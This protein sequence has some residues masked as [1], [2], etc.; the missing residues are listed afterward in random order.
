M[1][2]PPFK[3][4]YNSHCSNSCFLFRLTFP[5]DKVTIGLKRK[6]PV[7]DSVSKP[8]LLVEPYTIINRGPYPYNQPKR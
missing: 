2:V 1:Q 6:L 5:D 7:E 3:F 8:V 4:V